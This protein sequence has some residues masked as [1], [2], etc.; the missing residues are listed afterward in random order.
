MCLQPSTST[1]DKCALGDAAAQTLYQPESFVLSHLGNDDTCALQRRHFHKVHH[2]AQRPGHQCSS[3]Q[4]VIGLFDQQTPTCS[5]R[6]PSPLIPVYHKAVSWVCSFPPFSPRSANHIDTGNA[7]FYSRTDDCGL[8]WFILWVTSGL[9]PIQEGPHAPGSLWTPT[10]RPIHAESSTDLLLLT[11]AILL[12]PGLP[13]V[14]VWPSYLYRQGTWKD[15]NTN[16]GATTWAYPGLPVHALSIGLPCWQLH[17]YS[18][19]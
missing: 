17:L 11:W 16:A 14:L 3:V 2:Q 19:F 15:F 10:F 12:E 8:R 13:L 4:L 7:P 9:P 18:I 1:K 5:A 6:P